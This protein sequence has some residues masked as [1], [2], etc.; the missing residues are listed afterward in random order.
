MKIILRVILGV[1]LASLVAA[2]KPEK[3]PVRVRNPYFSFELPSGFK[4]KNF[5]GIDSYVEEYEADGIDLMFD[6]GRYS[7][8]FTGWPPSETEFQE[9]EVDGHRAFIGTRRSGMAAKYP[10]A[11]QINI[12]SADR[13]GQLTVFA[14]CRSQ[15][16]V[17]VAQK[18]FRSIQFEKENSLRG[19]QRRRIERKSRLST[20]VGTGS[21][22]R[23]NPES[24]HC[25]VEALD[26]GPPVI[27]RQ[28]RV[29]S[30]QK[31]RRRR[32]LAIIRVSYTRTNLVFILGTKNDL[33]GPRKARVVPSGSRMETAVIDFPSAEEK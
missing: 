30:G 1:V 31:N 7:N 32:I 6:Y 4:K 20:R 33:P 23:P 14:S 12:K 21:G 25:R 11:T 8:Q 10:I 28:I 19:A 9:L 3:R 13:N 18:I 2:A 5:S 29:P 16:E 15:K 22:G 17:D 24:S 26:A 27:G